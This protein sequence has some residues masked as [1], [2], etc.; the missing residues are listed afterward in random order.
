MR[1]ARRDSVWDA[2]YGTAYAQYMFHFIHGEGDDQS[3]G[4][5]REAIDEAKKWAT[6]IADEAIEGVRF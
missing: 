6:E 5:V 2:A 3:I 1:E 4:P